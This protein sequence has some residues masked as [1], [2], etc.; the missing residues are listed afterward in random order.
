[1]VTTLRAWYPSIE[2]TKSSIPKATSRIPICGSQALVSKTWSWVVRN[3]HHVSLPGFR[4]TARLHEYG[5]D[6]AQV[7]TLGLP[8]GSIVLVTGEDVRLFDFP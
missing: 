6:A 3:V 1:M 8:D 2:C 5:D 4:A 7:R